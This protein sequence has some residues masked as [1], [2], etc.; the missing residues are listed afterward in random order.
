MLDNVFRKPLQDRPFY[1]KGNPNKKGKKVD[2]YTFT[3][4]LGKGAYGEVKI[5]KK[6]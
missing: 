5:F 3:R 4:L 1:I 6:D 2:N